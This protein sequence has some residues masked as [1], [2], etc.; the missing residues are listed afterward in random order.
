MIFF[1]Y[2]FCKYFSDINYMSN[3]W[4]HVKQPFISFNKY[5]CEASAGIR[6]SGGKHKYIYLD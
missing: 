6:P 4:T 3:C 5:L 2:N 1:V